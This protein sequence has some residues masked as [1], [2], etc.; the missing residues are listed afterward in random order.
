MDGVLVG[1]SE[2]NQSPTPAVPMKRPRAAATRTPS[3]PKPG[4]AAPRPCRAQKRLFPSK[5]PDPSQTGT[6]EPLQ[7][8]R[9]ELNLPLTFPTGQTFTWRS[10]GADR[11]TGPVG[12]YLV[13]L[14]HHPSSAAVSFLVHNTN[15]TISHH[16]ALPLLRRFLNLEV[17]LARLWNSFSAADPR[18]AALAPYLAGARVLRQDPVECLFQFLCSSNNNIARIT[19]MVAFLSSL[20]GFLGSVG[21]FDFFEFPSLERLELVSEQELRQAGFGY[22]LSIIII[23]FFFFSFFI[24]IFE[25]V[26]LESC[27]LFA[28]FL[29]LIIEKF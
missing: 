23:I 14:R 20:G 26:E 6:W 29:I 7:I 12:P 21:G 4:R 17:S 11:F 18:F 24:F 10:T 9:S 2:L 15:D 8:G 22:R 1:A 13:S 16:R 19:K 27:L 3:F 25:I 5:P 28:V